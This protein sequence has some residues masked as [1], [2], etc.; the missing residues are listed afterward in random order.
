M[1]ETVENKF[2]GDSTFYIVQTLYTSR[3]LRREVAPF[4]YFRL[5]EKTNRTYRYENEVKYR[6]A[7]KRAERKL[8]NQS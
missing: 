7:I 5:N 1:W 2:I 8:I 6:K 4:S 3:L